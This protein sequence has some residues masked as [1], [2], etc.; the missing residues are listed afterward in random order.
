MDYQKGTKQSMDQCW[1]LQSHREKT[2]SRT[3]ISRGA[4]ARRLIA[5][6]LVVVN[7]G[8]PGLEWKGS[9]S[10]T[11]SIRVK[12]G[13]LVRAV[14]SAADK[15]LVKLASVAFDII[16]ASRAGWSDGF[17]RCQEGWQGARKLPCF[18]LDL[19]HFNISL[20]FIRKALGQ[21]SNPSQN[22]LRDCWIEMSF[23][24]SRWMHVI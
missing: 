16:V 24:N 4:D 23:I 11:S 12:F 21:N 5:M 18:F 8:C 1:K 15:T 10:S 14:V 3:K 20:P 22:P 13:K 19:L 7:Q 9:T 17:D 6:S 2:V